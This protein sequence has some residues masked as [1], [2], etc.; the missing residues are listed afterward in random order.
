MK[1][2]KYDCYSFLL[3]HVV[4]GQ[5]W[6]GCYKLNLVEITFNNSAELLLCRPNYSMFDEG[7]DCLSPLH[8]C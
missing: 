7:A 6:R 1:I 3:S 8:C 4:T 2:A 5:C